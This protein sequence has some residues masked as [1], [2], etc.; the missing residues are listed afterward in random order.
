MVLHKAFNK[1]MRQWSVDPPWLCM[2][3][4]PC[5][6]HSATCRNTRETGRRMAALQ[7]CTLQTV[8]WFASNS[9]FTSVSSA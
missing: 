2:Y 5:D 6:G 9:G 4:E 8:R 3:V 7:R 1:T